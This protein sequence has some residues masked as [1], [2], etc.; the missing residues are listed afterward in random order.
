MRRSL[1]LAVLAASLAASAH[2]DTA[3][4][5]R[6]MLGTYPF[7]HRPTAEQVKAMKDCDADKFYYGIG[8]HFDYVKARHCAFAKGNHDVLMMLYANGL[9]MPRN[10]AVAKM[11]A[12]QAK[13][14]P[15]ETQARLAHLTRM[16]GGREGPSP[17]IDICDS[18]SS[19]ALVARCAANRAALEEQA[20]D[21]QL[22]QIS[23][24]WSSEEKEAIQLVWKHAKAFGKKDALAWLQTFEAGKLPAD[25]GAP[26]AKAD[27]PPDWLAYQNAWMAFG[28]LR[29]PSVTQQ[30]WKAYFAQK[31][32]AIKKD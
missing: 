7:P 5:E 15:A 23:T 18:A 32:A 2:A 9:G 27:A 3:E 4:C 10:Y 22:E 25:D 14:D 8:L 24:R 16:Q 13:A 30:A 31:R 20:L 26:P 28:K 12:C 19:S 29:Y 1:A 21:E 17:T 11:A 6:H